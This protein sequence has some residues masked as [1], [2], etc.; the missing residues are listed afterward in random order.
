MN[1]S[2]VDHCEGTTVFSRLQEWRWPHEILYNIMENV[3]QK[4]KLMK[5]KMFSH[6]LWDSLWGLKTEY[7]G[8]N[9]QIS[10]ALP[11]YLSISHILRIVYPMSISVKFLSDVSEVSGED[12]QDRKLK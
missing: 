6:I 8:T 10:K 1:T 5:G 7:N 4:H 11:S 9:L 2:I 12:W 3:F